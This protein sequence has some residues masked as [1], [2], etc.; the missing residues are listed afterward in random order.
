[1][2]T[3]ILYV[4]AVL[5]ISS[6][7]IAQ[8][9]NLQRR[10]DGFYQNQDNNNG[11]NGISDAT[12]NAA[13][14]LLLGLLAYGAS[15]QP[16]S[17]NKAYNGDQGRYD[18]KTRVKSI[19]GSLLGTQKPQ[20]HGFGTFYFDNGDV[21]KGTWI[22]DRFEKG[23][24]YLKEQ[25]ILIE[26]YFVYEHRVGIIRKLSEADKLL[27]KYEGGFNYSYLPD[28]Y[29]ILS[30]ADGTLINSGIWKKG[31]LDKSIDEKKIRKKLVKLEK[32]AKKALKRK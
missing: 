7:T 30:D 26:G 9:E 24:Y 3:T 8:R 11:T 12:A 17:V 31:V 20:R 16:S 21:K 4:L 23:I 27:E 10:A 15:T 13:G 1:M 32:K 29:G 6:T 2:K 28:G 22:Y 14:A 18:G 19:L 25:N 5:S